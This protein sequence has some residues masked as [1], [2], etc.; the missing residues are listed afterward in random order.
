MGK[1]DFCD[2]KCPV[3]GCRTLSYTRVV[4]YTSDLNGSVREDD[5]WKP[6]I[7]DGST[8]S[9]C[10]VTITCMYCGTKMSRIEAILDKKQDNNNEFNLV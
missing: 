2:V 6:V 1:D 4:T 8:Q 5:L 9:Q 3:C 7:E 10:D